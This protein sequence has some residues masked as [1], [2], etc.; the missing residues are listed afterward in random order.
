MANEGRR[1]QTAGHVFGFQPLQQ[2]E[3]IASWFAMLRILDLP[4]GLAFAQ[5]L[6]VL[7]FCVAGD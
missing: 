1:V 7:A 5:E 2:Q 4:N 3:V 6:Y